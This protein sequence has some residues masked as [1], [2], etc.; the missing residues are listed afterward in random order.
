MATN[1]TYTHDSED[2]KVGITNEELLSKLQSKTSELYDNDNALSNAIADVSSKAEEALDVAQGKVQAV[3][4][5]DA[6][7]AYAYLKG[8]QDFKTLYPGDVIYILDTNVPDIWIA[9]VEAN[10]TTTEAQ[11]TNWLNKAI[12]ATGDSSTIEVGDYK[13]ARLETQKANLT[14]MVE[15]TATLPADEIILGGNTNKVKTSGVKISTTAPSSNSNDKTVPTSKAVNSAIGAATSSQVVGV[16]INGKDVTKT[17][18]VVNIPLATTSADGAMSSADKTALETLKTNWGST[19]PDAVGKV[20]DVKVNGTSVLDGSKIAQITLTIQ[21][22]A[23]TTTSATINSTTYYGFEVVDSEAVC[24][25]VFNSSGKEVI[26][27]KIMQTT[28][29]SFIACASA[30]NVT[31][32]ALLYRYGMA[33]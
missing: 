4:V 13:V 16:Q 1:P 26:T 23:K 8:G 11:F 28:G 14:N 9:G 24:I 6:S 29:K 12:G 20:Q 22:V 15:A 17:N 30:A 32:T 2:L 25:A 21:K 33:T 18:K 10:G 5:E 3:T 31:V 27:Q 7:A 19:T